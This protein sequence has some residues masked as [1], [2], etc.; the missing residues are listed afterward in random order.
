VTSTGTELPRGW[1][2]VRLREVLAALETGSRPGGGVVGITDGVPSVSAEQMTENGGF[3]FSSTRYVPREFYED[4]AD[5]R[6]RPDD[7]LIVKDGATTGK[8]SFVDEAF[9]HGEAVINEHVFLCRADKRSVVPRY[10]FL[11]LWAEEGQRAIRANY[12]GAAIGGINRRFADTVSVPLPPLPEQKRIVAILN[13][14]LSQVERARAAAEARLATAKALPAAYLRDV[15]E[16]EDAKAWPEHAL[17]E[18]S[19]LVIDGPHVTPEYV[20]AGVP[21]LTVR[22]IVNRS[23]DLSDASYISPEDHAVFQRRVRPQRGDILYTK[24]GTLGVP[25]LVDSSL[26]F[27]FFVSVALIRLRPEYADPRFV[28]LALDS[29]DLR[30]QVTHLADG[31]GL[32]HM[33]LKSIRALKVRLPSLHTQRAIA[34]QL[35]K[36]IAAAERLSQAARHAVTA[37]ETL[38]SSLLR[39]AFR[40]EL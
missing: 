30:Q 18:V 34:A 35:A 36:R 39:C 29:D 11:W 21:F 20:A 16:S 23:I 6:V 7:I 28:T 13:E 3:D 33:V 9:A 8:V 4:M 26:D 40:G 25:C 12:R 37:V 22:N 14:Q 17:A 10:L 31:A 32:K 1:R 27:S 38:P 5:G 19:S 24:D 15:F 2:W